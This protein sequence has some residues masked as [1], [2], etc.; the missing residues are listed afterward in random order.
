M[1]KILFNVF[2]PEELKD[3]I[4]KDIPGFPGYQASILG[5]FKSLDRTIKTNRGNRKVKGKILTVSGDGE[6]YSRVCVGGYWQLAHRL[7]AITFIPNPEN[8]PQVN[9]IDGV[10]FNNR[11]YNLEWCNQTENNLHAHNLG[12]TINNRKA[13]SQRMKDAW[14][15]CKQKGE[16]FGGRKPH[17]KEGKEMI[18]G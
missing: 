17:S 9:H 13:A 2:S 8:K 14:E 12:L 11:Y 4:W 5:R 6:W 3:E 16:R 15:K 18:C 7:T 10:K 1:G